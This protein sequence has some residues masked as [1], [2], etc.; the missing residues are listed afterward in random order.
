MEEEGDT[1]LLTKQ[2]AVLAILAML[3]YHS[4]TFYFCESRDLEY[5]DRENI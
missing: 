5:G 3:A 1:H 2:L 4:S